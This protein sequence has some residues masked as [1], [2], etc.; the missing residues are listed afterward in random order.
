M[1]KYYF[2]YHLVNGNPFPFTW[3]EEEGMPVGGRP[4]IAP[5][6]KIEITEEEFNFGELLPLERKYPWK[7]DIPL[8]PD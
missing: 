6:T 4:D 1:K 2:A 3:M 5:D 8:I 7:G